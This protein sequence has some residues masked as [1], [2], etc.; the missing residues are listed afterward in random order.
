MLIK[1]TIPYLNIDKKPT[2]FVGS[3]KQQN[4]RIQLA[5]DTVSF[6]GKKDLLD[7]PK[8]KIFQKI[9]K[10]IKNKYKLGEGSEA[11]VYRIQNTNYCIRK[12]FFVKN[13]NDE[14]DFELTIEDKINHVVAKLGDS[15]KIMK[16]IKGIPIATLDE[17]NQERLEYTEKLIEEFPVESYNKLIKQITYA[18][19][20]EMIFDHHWTNVLIDSEKQ[21]FTAI[22]FYPRDSFD[23]SEICTLHPLRSIFVSVVNLATSAEQMQIC[24]KKLLKAGLEEVK[25]N[26]QPYIE[27]NE[28]DF[29]FFLKWLI[30]N[31]KISMTKEDYEELEKKFNKI[32][33]LKTNELKGKAV[34]RSLM[35]EIDSTNKMIDK[36]L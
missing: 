11:A 28:F 18:Y 22:D 26:Y 3:I 6:T 27:L 30:S 12:P 25:P 13:I 10:S 34:K 35:K 4:L 29:T 5:Q 31:K 16:V 7:Q 1:P 23:H 36:I 15:C 24:T 8:E 21:T 14:I 33:K 20:N 17:K 32:I 9:K 19:K 2:K